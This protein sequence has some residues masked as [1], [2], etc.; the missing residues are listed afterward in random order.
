MD[1]KFNASHDSFVKKFTRLFYF[2]P[3]TE[4]FCS[5]AIIVDPEGEPVDLPFL[6]K[7]DKNLEGMFVVPKLRDSILGK[8]Y[9]TFFVVPCK[10]YLH[11]KKMHKSGISTKN[12]H[13]NPMNN[14]IKW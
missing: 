1:K 2:I 5:Y 6:R 8:K 14:L 7:K 4:Y 9:Q 11:F 10:C 3:N 12:G 13:C